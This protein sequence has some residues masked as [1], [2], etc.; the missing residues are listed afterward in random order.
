MSQSIQ[1]YITELIGLEKDIKS[2]KDYI[3]S[4]RKDLAKQTARA[5]EINTF[6]QEYLIQTNNPG[7]K[8]NGME[9]RLIQKN[10]RP[11]LDKDTSKFKTLEYIRSRGIEDAETFL[12]E[13]TGAK[14]DK[15]TVITKIKLKPISVKGRGRKTKE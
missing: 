5:K 14:L 13:L 3:K 11:P 8:Y 7:V 9:I 6:I 12:K 15:E 1:G 10:K 2:K 4:R